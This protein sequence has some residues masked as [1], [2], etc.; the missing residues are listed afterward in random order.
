MRD[1]FST[2]LILDVNGRLFYLDLSYKLEIL[3]L[4]ILVHLSYLF[5][6]DLL[7]F[8]LTSVSVQRV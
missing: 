5:G 4:S 8:I 6:L 7:K 2:N 3:S 1:V